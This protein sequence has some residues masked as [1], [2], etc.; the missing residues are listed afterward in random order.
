MDKVSDSCIKSQCD[1][2]LM[3]VGLTIDAVKSMTEQLKTKRE[4]FSFD[5]LNRLKQLI[6]NCKEGSK[7]KAYYEFEY[8]IVYKMLEVKKGQCL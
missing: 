7:L 6:N 1:Y 2:H 4:R 8:N 3:N 5:N